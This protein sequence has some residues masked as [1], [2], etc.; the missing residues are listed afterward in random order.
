MKAEELGVSKV[1]KGNQPLQECDVDGAIASYLCAIRQNPNES[2]PHHL[3][4]EALTRLGKLDAAVT[5]YRQAIKLNPDASESYY[6]LAEVIANQGFLEEA[7]AHY[8][9]ALELNPEIAEAYQQLGELLVKQGEL[10][11]AIQCWRSLTELNY[12]FS[13]NCFLDDFQPITTIKTLPEHLALTQFTL[14]KIVQEESGTKLVCPPGVE[15]LVSFGPYINLPDGLY[16]VKIDCESNTDEENSNIVA[17]KYDLISN[18]GSFIWRESEVYATQK[19]VEF[20]LELLEAQTIELRLWSTG[21][22]FTLNFIEFNLLYP[23]QQEDIKVGDYYLNLA[24]NLKLNNKL[25]RA[26]LAYQKGL[27]TNPEVYLKLVNNSD[28]CDWELLAT[29]CLRVLSQNVDA[30]SL[31]RLLGEA[32]MYIGK[33]EQTINTFL[34]SSA[35]LSSEEDSVRFW[36]NLA[37]HLSEQGFINEGIACFSL[38]SRKPSDR[39][40]YEKIWKGLNKLSPFDETDPYYQV[41]IKP[42]AAYSYFSETNSHTML[43]ECLTEENKSFLKKAGLSVACLELIKEENKALEE[44]YINSFSQDSFKLATKEGVKSDPDLQQTFFYRQ[45][46]FQ[47]SIVETG[48]IYAVCPFSGKI[49]RSNQSFYQLDTRPII[50]YRFDG[51]VEVF[52]LMVGDWPGGKMFLYFPSLELIIF[53]YGAFAVVLSYQ[54]IINNLKSYTV[55]SWQLVKSYLAKKDREVVALLGCYFV[56]GHYIWN[57]LGGLSQIYDL[58]LLEKIDKFLAMPFSFL[59]IGSIYPEIPPLNIIQA[60]RDNWNLFTTFLKN[61]YFIVRP[62]QT[63]PLKPELARRI[64]VSSRQKCS[65]DFLQVVDNAKNHWPLLWIQIRIHSR[66]WVSQVEGLGNLLKSL[67]VDYPTMGV[68]FVGNWYMTEG[69]TVDN[70]P[71]TGSI[72]QSEQ[73]VVRKIIALLPQ[74]ISTYNAVGCYNHEIQAWADAIDTYI[75]PLSSGFNFTN[76]ACKLGVLYTS[77]EINNPMIQEM[78]EKSLVENRSYK[79]IFLPHKYITDLDGYSLGRNYDCDW[80]GLYH[81]AVKIIEILKQKKLD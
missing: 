30:P 66:V 34:K 41:E 3:L 11:E 31:Y 35:M 39:E 80:K 81:E 6:K 58:G 37:R 8:R 73:E 74:E 54:V 36:Q 72:I 52:Y 65:Q 61:N 33:G 71:R 27:K 15:G 19:Q 55:S 40:I 43:L 68:V 12:E 7:I 20:F 46:Y 18:N 44:L 47:Q 69:E 63:Q 42:E 21:I 50:I 14:G 53:F 70:S 59:D 28:F 51:G 77:N 26:I 32:L 5:A 38:A 24:L 79:P 76:I 9:H 56:F 10:E 1:N 64:I 49:L 75:A 2:W 48:Y 17:F 25:E 78:C 60:P 45:M 16:K 13:S 4:G 23:N 67:H 57:E 62:T 22:G 29:A